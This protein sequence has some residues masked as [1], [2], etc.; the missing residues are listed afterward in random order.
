MMLIVIVVVIVVII[1]IMM[2]RSVVLFDSHR[3]LLG[4]Q[5][6]PSPVFPCMFGVAAPVGP[7]PHVLNPINP[8]LQRVDEIP[9][10]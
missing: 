5:L 4:A 7:T 2:H 9:K 8:F 3:C 1:I 6:T 10:W